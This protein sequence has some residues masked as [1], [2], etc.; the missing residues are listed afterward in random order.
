[1]VRLIGDFIMSG[2][3]AMLFFFWL[4]IREAVRPVGV[5]ERLLGYEQNESM[6]KFRIDFQ[7]NVRYDCLMAV[8][9]VTPA[10]ARQFESLPRPIKLRV[11][12]LLERLGN[13]PNVSGA[14]PLR[15]RL[16]NRYR[17]RTG[18]YRLQFYVV[19]E[20]VIVERIG[21]RDGFYED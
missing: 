14:K 3:I 17:M 10:A 11:T 2:A 9:T 5:L 4:I 12:R 15:G 1:V 13:W 18:D 7:R 19:E 20:N 6:P 21:H 16:A 8:V